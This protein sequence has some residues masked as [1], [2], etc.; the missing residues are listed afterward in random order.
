[1]LRARQSSPL[2]EVDHYEDDHFGGCVVGF[3]VFLRL[4]L[5]AC[6]PDVP[7]CGRQDNSPFWAAT[8]QVI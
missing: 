7:T 8:D 4:D 1:M 2:R 6:Y 3:R 5:S